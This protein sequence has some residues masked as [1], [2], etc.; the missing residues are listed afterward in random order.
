[1]AGDERKRTRRPRGS[2]PAPTSAPPPVGLSA[3]AADEPAEAR[4]RELEAELAAA[5]KTIRA[6]LDK[7]E[8]RELVS[9]KQLR[10][11]EA[12]ARMEQILEERTR[13]VQEKGEALSRANAELRD[14]T[15][16]L[17]HIV[18]QRTRALHE[19]EE[20]LRRKNEELKR[21]N[22]MKGE[23]ISIAAHE[24]RTPMTSIVGYLDLMS[25]GRFGKL[26]KRLDRP[27]A[28]LRRNAQRLSR[29]VEE[30]L[31]VSRLESGRMAIHPKPCRLAEI[32]RAV[33]EELTPFSAISRQSITTDLASDPV[34]HA[35]ADKIHQVVANLTASAIRYTP[36][37]GVI[38]IGV[39]TAPEDQFAGEW[40]RLRVRDNGLGIPA[41]LRARI[42]EPFSDVH[43]AKH[44]T[45]SGPDSAG[46]GLY[47]ARG[48][49]DLHGGLI[50]VDSREGEFTEFTVLLPLSRA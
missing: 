24:L 18:R 16:N 11:D 13:E 15:T 12:A 23:F 36:D 48:L 20:Q 43:T 3:E 6:L 25:E 14:L 32:V 39:D 2:P 38:T 42:F 9:S 31:D 1:M 21:M 22:A 50:T 30:M 45:S 40:A 41:S 47:I 26:P 7:A 19:S 37:D 49:V 8:E 17:D 46:L 44:H 4:I 35:D 28:A 33:V 29:L 34:I 5:H 10:V 27:V